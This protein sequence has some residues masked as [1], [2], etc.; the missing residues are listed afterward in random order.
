[1]WAVLD[2]AT[3]GWRGVIVTPAVTTDGGAGLRGAHR[4]RAAAIAAAQRLDVQLEIAVVVVV[5]T[6]PRQAR[7]PGV[8]RGTSR[9]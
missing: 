6:G 3:G 7:E 2:R 9:Q 5:P 8:T 1:L 4:N